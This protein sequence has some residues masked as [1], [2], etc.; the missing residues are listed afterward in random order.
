MI[1]VIHAHPYLSR[2]RIHR[3]LADAVRALEDVELRPLYDLY[4]DF[5]IDVEA[6]Q[7]A[8]ARARLVVWMHPVY[9]YSVPAL[10]KHWFD[11]VLAFGWAYGEG[12][13]AIKGKHCLW[14]P[15]TGG[16]EAA[17]APGGLHSRPFASFAP[18]IEQ[19]ARYCGMQ[20]ES[21]HIIYGAND[22]DDAGLAL[23]AAALVRQLAPWRGIA[24]TEAPG[25]TP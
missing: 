1:C 21:P 2:S 23:H 14:V 24:A 17:Y 11:K 8:L 22:I 16:D 10:L 5:D 9:W 19:T 20:W 6:E 25:E 4:P 3:A 18:V 12:G 15:T 7:A 13:T